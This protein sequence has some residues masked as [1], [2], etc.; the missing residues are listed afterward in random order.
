M[1][2]VGDLCLTEERSVWSTNGVQVSRSETCRL[3]RTGSSDVISEAGRI[4][5]TSSRGAEKD[6]KSTSRGEEFQEWSILP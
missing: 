3:L 4:R 1:V 6:V 5:S 2:N